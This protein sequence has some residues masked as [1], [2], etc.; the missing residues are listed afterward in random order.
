M[1]DEF[2]PNP[3]GFPPNPGELPPNP[4]GFPPTIELP[5]VASDCKAASSGA[6]CVLSQGYCCCAASF[7]NCESP[8][9]NSKDKFANLV[10]VHKTCFKVGWDHI[11]RCNS[12][13][14]VGEVLF[15]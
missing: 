12:F 6:T 1:E 7:Y 4:G 2:P 11:S 9:S 5:L 13:V 14:K 3:G 10:V 8:E 15:R